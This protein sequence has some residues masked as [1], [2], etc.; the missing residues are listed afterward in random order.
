[1]WGEKRKGWD[2]KVV[3][4]A[5][6]YCQNVFSEPH[7]FIIARWAGSLGMGE[8]LEGV[9]GGSGL[10]GKVELRKPEVL[11]TVEFELSGWGEEEG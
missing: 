10:K 11:E 3:N 1:M 9:W 5:K 2:G 8:G 6:N 4:V 7:F